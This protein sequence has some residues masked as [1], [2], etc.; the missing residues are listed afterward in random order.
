MFPFDSLGT[1]EA[2]HCLSHKRYSSLK[3]HIGGNVYASA[4]SPTLTRDIR[5]HWLSPVNVFMHAT[6]QE[7]TLDFEQYDKLMDVANVLPTLLTELKIM[8]P[9]QFT[10]QTIEGAIYCSECH[11]NGPHV[12]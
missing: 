4:E 2:V 11:L 8:L 1:D 5:H 10:H 6:P 12:A 3:R 9:C 7:V